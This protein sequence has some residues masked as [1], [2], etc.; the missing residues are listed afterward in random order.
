MWWNRVSYAANNL[1][2]GRDILSMGFRPYYAG[3]GLGL[4]SG[5]EFLQR[6]DHIGG[7]Y[8]PNSQL[9]SLVDNH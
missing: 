4:H 3:D 8:I 2:G 6:P 7:V 1:Q 5:E 9:S